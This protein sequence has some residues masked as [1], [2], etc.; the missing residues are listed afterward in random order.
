MF[1]CPLHTWNYRCSK[2]LHLIYL[3]SCPTSCVA[4]ITPLLAH[5]R[6]RAIFLSSPCIVFIR[7]FAS[8]SLSLS[9]LTQHS[10]N[11]ESVV[12]RELFFSVAS[13]E[14]LS[15]ALFT[16]LLFFPSPNILLTNYDANAVGKTTLVTPTNQL[17]PHFLLSNQRTRNDYDVGALYT[18][19]PINVPHVHDAP[20]FKLSS[21]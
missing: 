17:L 21:N 19:E 12:V 1:V 2:S 14:L 4:V 3:F 16:I 18:N 7:D 8:N 5:Y 11:S 9:L 15:L 20:I 13:L 10:L 6:G